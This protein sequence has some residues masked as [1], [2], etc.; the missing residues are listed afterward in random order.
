MMMSDRIFRYADSVRLPASAARSRIS[1]FVLPSL[2]RPLW[3]GAQTVSTTKEKKIDKTCSNRYC[4][5]PARR[6]SGP[7]IPGGSMPRRFVDLSI[8]LENDVQS[9]PPGFG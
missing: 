2:M 4:P 9:D 6:Q 5:Y 1:A 8:F 3:A 7:R